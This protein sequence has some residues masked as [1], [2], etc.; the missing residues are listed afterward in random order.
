MLLAPVAALRE[1]GEVIMRTLTGKSVVWMAGLS[2]WLALLAWVTVDGWAALPPQYQRWNEFA[3]VVREAS[4]PHKLS[5]PVNRI[6]H[7]KDSAYRVRAGKC[8][9][10]VVLTVGA[11]TTSTGEVLIGPS[12]IKQVD[13]GERRCD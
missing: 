1:A 12:V 2:G 13:V 6:E 7:V 5:G 4:V 11:A 8:H 10:D 3:A 9:V